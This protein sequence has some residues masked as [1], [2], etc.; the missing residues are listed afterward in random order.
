[1]TWRMK[2]KVDPDALAG[3]GAEDGMFHH[4]ETIKI[5]SDNG[6]RSTARVERI[7]KLEQL[8]S[9][10][11][12]ADK[13]QRQRVTVLEDKA[14]D[15]EWSFSNTRPQIKT[16]DGRFSLALRDSAGRRVRSSEG[17]GARRCGP[18]ARR[19][20]RCRDPHRCA[21]LRSLNS[22]SSPGPSIGCRRPLGA[23]YLHP[24]PFT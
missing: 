4:G 2:S 5:I 10:K 16:G 15:V 22:T 6:R 8:L 7:E 1:M 21:C 12:E 20:R 24:H 19:A 14:K 9:D 13:E 3:F 17:A 18:A 23:E 11:E